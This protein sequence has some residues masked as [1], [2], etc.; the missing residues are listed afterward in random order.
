MTNSL[1]AIS[2]SVARDNALLALRPTVE[3]E[4]SPATSPAEQFQNQTLRPILKFQHELLLN[5]FRDYCQKRKD[6]FARLP[7]TERLAYIEHALQT[8]QKFKN[9]LV[10]YVAG[11]FTVG[12]WRTFRDNE[13]ELTR[14][15]VSLLIQ[16]LQSPEREL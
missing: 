4:D 16:R 11:H 6:T 13:A 8:D 15:V 2:A 1:P 14:R 5:T 7:R 12:E 9:R 3:T 10:G